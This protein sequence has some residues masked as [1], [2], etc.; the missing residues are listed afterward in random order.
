MSALFNVLL[1]MH[2]PVPT[3]HFFYVRD[4]GHC[5]DIL[6]AEIPGL[7]AKYQFDF[8]KYDIDIMANY[9]LLEKMEEHVEDVGEDLPVIFVLDSVFYGPVE[10]R[11]NLEP[12]LEL[13]AKS[14][15]PK[16]IKNTTKIPPEKIPPDTIIQ[17]TVKHAA[18]PVHLYYFYQPGCQGCDRTGII[19]DHIQKIHEQIIVHRYD[20]LD[21][22]GKIF[23]EALSQKLGFPEQERLI[24]PAIII[25]GEFL[26]RHEITLA[27]LDS[28]VQKFPMGSPEYDI[29]DFDRAEKNIIERFAR[30][31]IFGIIFAGLLD[32]INPCAFATLIFFVSYLLFIG[33]S[34]KHIVIMSVFFILAVF[35]SYY[36]IGLGAYSLLKF[37]AHYAIISKIIFLCFG[38]IAIML[39]FLSLRDYLLARKGRFD[40][41]ILQLPLSIKQRI[42]KNIKEKTALGGIIV[43]SLIAG[44]FISYLEFGCTGQVYLPTITFMISKAGMTIKPLFSLFVYNLMFILPLII[45]A[46]LASLFTT[47]RI[48]R[49]L[50]RKI[51]TIK[52][53]TALL[54]FGLG[55]LLILSS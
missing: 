50:E 21:D 11:E 34:R 27:D 40:K 51:P 16:V 10:A 49:S 45:I 42:H 48:A 25:S 29:L 37:L 4:C 5:M 41:M 9:E 47:Q 6:L 19:L 43:G 55:I 7:Q 35:V 23:F 22:S 17:D 1:F 12:T 54:F 24:V 3:M 44:F 32:G 28:L 31:S 18:K 39:G 46:L 30:F 13:Y 33:R 52:L 8:R 15:K 2:N 14:K 26:S 53:L 36:A 20:I 38:G